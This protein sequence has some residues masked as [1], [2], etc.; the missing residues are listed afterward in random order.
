MIFPASSLECRKKV[1]VNFEKSSTITRQYFFFEMDIML[2]GP[3]KSICKSWRGFTIDEIVLL[4][5]E[6]LFCF[7]SW[8]APQSPFFE[9][10][11]FGIPLTRS[12]FTNSFIVLKFKWDNL[13]CH[14][15]LSS[16]LAL[17]RKQVMESDL[18]LLKSATYTFP[19][20]CPISTT[21]PSSPLVTTQAAGVKLSLKPL[22]EVDWW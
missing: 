11:S 3:N 7:P 21:L 6:L 13:L 1:Q 14:S 9:N 10:S 20:L 22:S 16:G 4:L 12:F 2:T 8:Q 5:K 18:I 17:L 15:Q 19:F